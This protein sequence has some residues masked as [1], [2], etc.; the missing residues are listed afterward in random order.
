MKK[1]Y[2]FLFLFWS[3]AMAQS[4][5]VTARSYNQGSDKIGGVQVPGFLGNDGKTYVFQGNPATF[6]YPVNVVS[7]AA[8]SASLQFLRNLTQTSVSLDT[9]TP[10]NN[11]PLPVSLLAG[12]GLGPVS[13]GAGVSTNAIRTYANVGLGGVEISTSNRLATSALN[14]IEEASFSATVSNSY[15]ATNFTSTDISTKRFM[16]V[17]VTG[18]TTGLQIEGQHHS[19]GTWN[20]M[21]TYN[22]GSDILSSVI[23]SDGKYFVDLAGYVSFRFNVAVSS[24][25]TVVKYSL[26]ESAGRQYPQRTLAS[27][28]S[29]ASTDSNQIAGNNTL[30]SIDT[31]I[32]VKGQAL[33][34]ASMPVVLPSTQITA[35]TPQIDALTNTQLRASP[36]S[37]TLQNVGSSA[38][39]VNNGTVYPYLQNFATTP[40]N[41]L[42]TTIIG[43]TV[44]II[45]SISVFNPQTEPIMIAL[46]ASGLELVQYAAAQGHSSFDLRIPIGSRISL[47]ANFGTISTGTFVMNARQ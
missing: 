23:T 47:R 28:P 2:L 26:Q 35:L 25:T 37:V 16:A 21:R 18:V 8:T 29:G 5:A 38:A 32:P 34:A 10:A 11:R 30:T 33:A 15:N 36:V 17:E 44:T 3:N 46:G 24:G 27:L 19:T 13:V 45:N 14:Q 40:Q 9:V 20:I 1:I 39:I 43:T 41:I 12:D 42:Y 4:T 31:K 22:F 6:A 7:S